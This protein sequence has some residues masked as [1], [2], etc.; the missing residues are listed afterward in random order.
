MKDSV[1]GSKAG[2]F[3]GEFCNDAIDFG[4]DIFEKETQ[5]PKRSI[6]PSNVRATMMGII[7]LTVHKQLGGSVPIFCE[8]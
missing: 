2:E 5:L 8:L 7:G 3:V 6:E 4:W 1:N